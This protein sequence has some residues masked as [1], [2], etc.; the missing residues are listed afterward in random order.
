MTTLLDQILFIKD[1][2]INNNSLYIDVGDH[3]IPIIY[4]MFKNDV[5]DYEIKLDDISTKYIDFYKSIYH[6]IQMNNISRKKDIILLSNTMRELGDIYIKKG[7]VGW[8]VA[9]GW[10]TKSADL[11]NSE[12]MYE[13]A[14]C[15][16]HAKGCDK[17]LKKAYDMYIKA[18]NLNNTRALNRLAYIYDIGADGIPQDKKMTFEYFKKSAELGDP[19][20]MFCLGMR[21]YQGSGTDKSLLIALKWFSLSAKKDDINAK[22]FIEKI[23][24]PDVLDV[25]V[26]I[27]HDNEYLKK[28][29]E[30]LKL[31]PGSDYKKAE[32]DFLQAG[33]LYD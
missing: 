5:V 7:I 14:E 29:N 19:Y 27:Y 26:D 2:L 9:F 6:T 30:H 33:L 24:F 15:Y 3:L 12:S 28:M 17:D 16:W 8:K 11:G 1:Y 22:I 13:L 21:Y 23:K 18:A 4:N 10:Y 32:E 25:I 31:Y 20:G